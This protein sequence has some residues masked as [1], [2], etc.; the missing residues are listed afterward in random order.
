MEESVARARVREEGK[1]KEEKGKNV[2][3]VGKASS[4]GGAIFMHWAGRRAD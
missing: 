3:T 2:H 1:G 4:V